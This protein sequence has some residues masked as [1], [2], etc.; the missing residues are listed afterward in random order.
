MQ[1]RKK[2]NPKSKINAGRKD[3]GTTA[4][5]RRFQM[6]TKNIQPGKK[7]R[8]VGETWSAGTPCLRFPCNL[9]NSAA[10]C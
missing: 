2:E 3:D 10:E 1:S 8:K 5:R 9:T 7:G 4:M 6:D